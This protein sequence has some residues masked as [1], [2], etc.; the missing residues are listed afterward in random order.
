MQG[1]ILMYLLYSNWIWSKVSSTMILGEYDQLLIMTWKFPWWPYS[2]WTQ[3]ENGSLEP[4]IFK[5][6]LNCPLALVSYL[7]CNTFLGN[8]SAFSETNWS[9]CN[10]MKMVIPI[11]FKLLKTKF[12]NDLFLYL[13]TNSRC[14]SKWIDD[15]V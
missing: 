12:E 4:Q 7:H 10:Q 8:F 2:H 1:I 9:N 15:S 13:K 14:C 11:A 6:F 3:W 5:L